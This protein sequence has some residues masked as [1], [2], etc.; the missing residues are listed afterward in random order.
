MYC[1]YKIDQINNNIKERMKNKEKVF[2]YPAGKMT[3]MFLEVV[4]KNLI[5]IIGI[6][7]KEDK[8]FLNYTV[9]R[10]DI[11]RSFRNA[12]VIITSRKYEEEIREEILRIKEYDGEIITAFLEDDENKEKDFCSNIE[13]NDTLY[14]QRMDLVLT[15]KCSLRCEKCANLMQY[16]KVGKD[17]PV[18]VIYESMDRLLNV[19]DFLETVY[20]LGG[21]PFLYDYL[22]DVL[23]FLKTYNNIG[24]IEV[25]TNGTIQVKDVQLW[26]ELHDSRTV[27]SISNYGNLSRHKDE[28]IQ[29]C[30]MYHINYRYNE[31]N[32]FYDTGNMCKRNRSKDELQKVFRDCG[33]QC[34]SLYMGELHYC[35]RSAHGMDL[36]LVPRKKSD[37]INL[38]NKTSRLELKESILRFIERTDYIL[39]CDY[40]DIR[41]GNYYNKRYPA[42]VQTKQVLEI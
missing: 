27:L 3:K 21:E 10:V 16:Y 31:E 17:V 15:T 39:T 36:G 25:V 9:F 35:P 14:I 30:K 5:N 32:W 26:N 23:R 13:G 11:L 6:I 37:Y 12:T 8:P 4:D 18:N 42:G 33:T 7:D 34:R 28:L 24:Q 19:V 2:I 29:S 20:V 40:C 22:K 41:V 38:L 1:L